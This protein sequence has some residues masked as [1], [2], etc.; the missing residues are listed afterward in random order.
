M[1]IP[2]RKVSLNG[3]KLFEMSKNCLDNEFF[4]SN[5]FLVSKEDAIVYNKFFVATKLIG[6]LRNFDYEIMKF[7]EKVSK[8]YSIQELKNQRDR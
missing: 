5:I 7:F 1:T 3:F 2:W 6:K 4:K 8:I